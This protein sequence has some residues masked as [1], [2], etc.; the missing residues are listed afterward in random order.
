M[1]LQNARMSASLPGSCPAN[2]LHG[3][4]STLKPRS[5][6]CW[7]RC[8][9]PAYWGVRP[10]FEATLTTSTTLPL[11]G[12]SGRSSPSSAFRVRS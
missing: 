4:P 12:A 10:H 6:Y 1:R 3:R 2:W 11:N 7:Y 5:R 9:S 8:S